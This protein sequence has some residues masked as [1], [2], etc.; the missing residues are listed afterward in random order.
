[1]KI[2]SGTKLLTTKE[3]ASKLHVHPKLVIRW[4][5]NLSL[6][7]FRFGKEFRFDEVEV[8]EWIEAH[9]GNADFDAGRFIEERARRPR[10]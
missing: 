4:I 2:Q 6:P 9:R 3:I 8:N 10:K 1:M 7:Y 5:T